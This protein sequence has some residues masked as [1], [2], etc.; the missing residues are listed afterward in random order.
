M[1]LQRGPFKSLW[2]RTH[3]KPERA[4]F[5]KAA[6]ACVKVHKA[7]MQASPP[8]AAFYV[9]VA[10][11]SLVL[12]EV[13][14]RC[15]EQDFE[16]HPHRPLAEGSATGEFVYYK[17]FGPPGYKSM[18]HAYASSIQG[19]HSL[20]LSPDSTE[21]LLVWENGNWKMVTGAID[22]GE[23]ALSSAMRECHEEVNVVIDSEFSPLLVGGHQCSNAR[24][25]RVSDN[26]HVFVLR[27]KSKAFTEDNIEI[28]QAKWFRIDAL[29]RAEASLSEWKPFDKVSAD[30]G[31]GQPTVVQSNTL[32]YARR[33][34][35]G[36]YLSCKQDTIHNHSNIVWFGVSEK[37]SV[38]EAAR[39]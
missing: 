19:T 6:E 16:F 1:S 9:A 20:V 21:V 37:M 18:V 13:V 36:S 4:D 33:F 7:E 25:R 31:D 29:L 34:V 24:D 10:E 27:A 12:T 28:K 15:R 26:V 22:P 38:T 8:G 30:L 3:G 23:D 11:N 17:W 14:Q 2:L 32:R 39:C 5:A 35:E